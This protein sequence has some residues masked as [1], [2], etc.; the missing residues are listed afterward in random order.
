MFGMYYDQCVTRI[1]CGQFRYGMM[2]ADGLVP[3]WHQV[4]EF[5]S[6]C[7]IFKCIVVITFLN[8]SSVI[9]FESYVILV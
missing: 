2:V 9:A 1:S 4:G 7:I 5:H 3:I 6:K 8:A